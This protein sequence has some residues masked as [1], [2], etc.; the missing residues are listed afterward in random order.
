MSCGSSLQLVRV[1]YVFIYEQGVQKWGKD[2]SLGSSSIHDASAGRNT[3]NFD[4]LV[5]AAE[6]SQESSNTSMRLVIADAA[7]QRVSVG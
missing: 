7:C 5:V 1:G 2:R 6:E 4:N 3:V